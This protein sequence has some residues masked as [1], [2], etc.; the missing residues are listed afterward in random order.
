MKKVKHLFIVDD[1]S[2]GYDL[3]RDSSYLFIKELKEQKCIVDVA[4]PFQLNVDLEGEVLAGS[5]TISD[6]D[7]VWVRKDPPIDRTY[8]EHLQLLSLVER[9]YP[10]IK[11]VNSPTSVLEIN[12][13]LAIFNFKHL[14]PSTLLLTAS[15][16]DMTPIYE[17]MQKTGFA[18]LKPLNSFAGGGV[19]KVGMD[20]FGSIRQIIAEVADGDESYCMVQEFIPEVSLGDTRIHIVNGKPIGALLR[21]PPSDGFKGNIHAGG[22]AARG[23][24]SPEL[25]KL[26]LEIGEWLVKKGIFFAGIDTINGKLTEINVT[27]PGV[28]VE[29]NETSG[30]QLE[31]VIIEELNLS[32]I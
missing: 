1:Y 5:F 24:L 9:K 19:R 6:Y 12:E 32:T 11:F 25:E 13:K 3:S 22:T 10:K 2:V 29:T 7:V 15:S 28:I 8:F 17:M 21:V 14:I 4:H 27:S 18:V 20:E 16:A 31:K 26:A 23:V 30:I